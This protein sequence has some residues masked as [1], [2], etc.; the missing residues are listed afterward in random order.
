MKIKTITCHDVYNAGASLQAYALMT[1]LQ[2]LG[3][4]VEIINYKP[5]YLSNHYNLWS[6]SNPKYEKNILL[7]FTYLCLKLPKRLIN[8]Y[9]KKK[10]L[11][12]AFTKKYLNVTQ[13]VYHS[14]EELVKNLPEA[15]VYIAGSDQIW[16]SLFNNGKD[17]AF[18]LN[19]VPEDK[20]KAS[21]AASFATNKIAEGYE[22]CV[23]Q[24]L[25]RLDYIGIRENSGVKLAESLGI[26]K[27][28]HVLDPVF[29]LERKEWDQLAKKS[30][31]KMNNEKYLIVYDFDANE[32]IKELCLEVSKKLNL[33]IYSFFKND[34]ADKIITNYGPIEFLALIKNS[35][36]VVSNS[37][38]GTAFSI[39]YEK[40]FFVVNRKESLNSRMI[41]LLSLLGLDN[42]LI[43]S[44]KE[45]S[46]EDFRININKC[47]EKEIN[48][49]KQYITM[50][51]KNNTMN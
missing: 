42:R 3:N 35:S 6:I 31:I 51:L 30:S 4:D 18:Y 48:K 13:N 22:E 45:Y 46:K 8:K 2:N 7:K 12:D 47:L 17:P 27:A 41:D 44:F 49:S 9:S 29:L 32:Q 36:F 14:N 25:K 20:I 10:K 16:N 39:I 26:E 19:F 34:Y 28:V 40:P 21:Y 23:T 15:E 24:W 5:D 50:V 11:F 33:K 1:Y 37:F 38:H 43:S